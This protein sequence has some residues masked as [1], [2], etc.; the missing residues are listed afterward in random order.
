[1]D[2]LLRP[3]RQLLRK[4]VV[5]VA[6]DTGSV[7]T[8]FF[9]APG[10]VITCAHVVAGRPSVVWVQAGDVRQSATVLFA[11]P[12]EA[13]VGARIFPYPDIALLAV[14][15]TAE[16]SCAWLGQARPERHASLYSIGYQLLYADDPSPSPLA[17]EAVGDLEIPGGT[18]IRIRGDEVDERMSGSPVLDE[19]TGEVCAMIKAARQI[20]TDR[21][22]VAITLDA[23]Q[24]L[25]TGLRIRVLRSHDRWHQRGQW[26]R[27]LDALAAERHR[28]A[29]GHGLGDPLLPPYLRGFLLGVL[30]ELPVPEDP[31]S[32]LQVL[33]RVPVAPDI[34]VTDYRDIAFYFDTAAWLSR[35]IQLHPLV[36]FLERLVIQFH[37][38][39][40]DVADRLWTVAELLAGRLGQRSQLG[41]R[42]TPRAVLTAPNP[43]AASAEGRSVIVNVEP[44]GND[45]RLHL[46]SIRLD[47][48][49]GDVVQ[50]PCDR[51]PR[52]LDQVWTTVRQIL[53]DA[54]EDLGGGTKVMVQVVLA[55]RLLRECEE[56]WENWRI[57]PDMPHRRLGRSHPVVVRA[58]DVSGSRIRERMRRDRWDAMHAAGAGPDVARVR[59]DSGT[60]DDFWDGWYQEPTRLHSLVVLPGPPTTSPASEAFRI[61]VAEGLPIAI[62]RRRPCLDHGLENGALIEPCTGARFQRSLSDH[63]RGVSVGGLPE[64]ARQL[65][66]DAAT[67]LTSS[68]SPHP[69]DG[70]VLYW[71]PPRSP[72]FRLTEPD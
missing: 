42:V 55:E 1:M 9:I 44:H 29:P 31:L 68:T 15:W 2:R 69:G 61:G 63:L 22:G 6:C 67:S 58:A 39:S 5:E 57:W 38:E 50:Y 18:A 72:P 8:G 65:R 11:E 34:R 49:D 71:D 56:A 36:E 4:A 28:A 12:R 54:I 46:L 51:T 59:C 14:E 26:V 24:R 10:I 60:D 41:D 30:A 17:F 16:Y 19:A 62:W 23:L 43:V 48:G 25:P 7:G 40:S 45:Q 27:S 47:R 37:R 70:L 64:H 3:L 52:A 53:P 20:G 33:N 13:P 35:D 32:M 21:G 66:N